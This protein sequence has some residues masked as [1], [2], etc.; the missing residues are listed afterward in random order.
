[1]LVNGRQAGILEEMEGG[2]Y[3]FD[4]CPDYSGP[5]VSL[6]LPVREEE[7]IFSRF[8]PFFD[9]LLPEGWQLEALLRSEKLDPRDYMGQLLK[10]GGDAVGSVTVEPRP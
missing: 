1:V 10:V 5:P 8:P 3:R 2:S 7:Y 4:Y 6:T 9:G